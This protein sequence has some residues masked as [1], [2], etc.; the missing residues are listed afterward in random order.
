MSE[1]RVMTG[2]SSLKRDHVTYMMPVKRAHHAGCKGEAR[3]HGGTA[4]T[5]LEMTWVSRKELWVMVMTHAKS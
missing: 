2:P 5:Q 4:V 1:V 3:L